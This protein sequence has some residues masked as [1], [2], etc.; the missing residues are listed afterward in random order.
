[1][2]ERV[3]LKGE[4][5]ALAE[6]WNRAGTN[7]TKWNS[8]PRLGCLPGTLHL[9]CILTQRMQVRGGKGRERLLEAS[10]R[11]VPVKNKRKIKWRGKVQ[12]NPWHRPLYNSHP[13]KPLPCC[14][15]EF[16]S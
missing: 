7:G 8:R 10:E 16:K 9:R 5:V 6:Q 3:V 13:P 14:V 11:G 15:T 4:M 2:R 12:E 1:M